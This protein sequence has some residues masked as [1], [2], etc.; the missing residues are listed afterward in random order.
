VELGLD[1]VVGIVLD[2]VETVFSIV[3][4]VLVI[5]I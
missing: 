4:G 5:P 2:V 3:S 1:Q